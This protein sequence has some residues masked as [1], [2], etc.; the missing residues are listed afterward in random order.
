[1]GLLG[2][3]SSL[4]VGTDAEFQFLKLER[5]ENVKCLEFHEEAHTEHRPEQNGDATGNA[6]GEGCGRESQR[7]PNNQ[8]SS[9]GTSSSSSPL[10][11]GITFLPG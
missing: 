10:R 6:Y 3:V 2:I 11:C 9:R 4:E 1:M 5:K 8:Q 7:C